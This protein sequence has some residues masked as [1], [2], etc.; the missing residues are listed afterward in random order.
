MARRKPATLIDRWAKLNKYRL[1]VD[2]GAGMTPDEAIE[3]LKLALAV[4]EELH[5]RLRLV[6]EASRFGYTIGPDAIIY[7]PDAD[8]N[9]FPE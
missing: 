4:S 5:R 6:L 1:M 3:G 2:L 8:E 7:D 9:Q